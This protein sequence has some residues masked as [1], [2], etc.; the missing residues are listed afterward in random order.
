[1]VRT[2]SSSPP[3]RGGVQAA[4]AAREVIGQRPRAGGPDPRVSGGHSLLLLAEQPLVQ[5]LSR[6]L[7]SAIGFR[8]LAVVRFL[9]ERF[10]DP[11]DVSNVELAL[12]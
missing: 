10:I 3:G 2:R 5:F 4:K 1:M 8:E 6:T 11:A 12:A 7:P 9:D